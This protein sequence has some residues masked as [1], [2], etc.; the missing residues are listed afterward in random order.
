M[1]D[2][3][4]RGLS[5]ATLSDFSASGVKACMQ[6]IFTFSLGTFEP[7]PASLPKEKKLNE[8]KV[9]KLFVSE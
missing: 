9:L 7:Y 1:E 2:L 3:E 8:K 6:Y 5:S 4:S